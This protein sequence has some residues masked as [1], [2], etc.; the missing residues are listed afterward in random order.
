MA[1]A[2]RALRGAP[3]SEFSCALAAVGA[4]LES[5]DRPAAVIG[6]V[7]VIAHGFA[8]LTADVDAAVV[9]SPGGAAELVKSARRFGLVP[10]V[11]EA[12]AFAAENLVL[13]LEHAETHV[14]VDVSLAQQAFERTAAEEAELRTVGDVRLPVVPLTALLIYKMV[15]GRPKDLEDVRAL[16]ATGEAWDEASVVAALE[17]FDAILDTDRASE[18]RRLRAGRP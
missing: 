10:R 3:R 15:A 8:R 7:A 18:L 9:T 11:D 1:E 17:E 4:W 12:V 5:L 16:L 6:G 14:P 2:G 13:L